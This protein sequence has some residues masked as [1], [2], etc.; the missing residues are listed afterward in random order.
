MSVSTLR[1][2]NP[3]VV[4]TQSSSAAA[5]TMKGGATFDGNP[6]DYYEWEFRIELKKMRLE[7]ILKKGRRS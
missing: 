4:G 1:F 7:A 5:T 2:K 6:S 3:K